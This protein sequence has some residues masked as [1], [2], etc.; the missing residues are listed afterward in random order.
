MKEFPARRGC[1]LVSL[2]R[3]LQLNLLRSEWESRRQNFRMLDESQTV[4]GNQ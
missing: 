2:V 3:I 4:A 1:V